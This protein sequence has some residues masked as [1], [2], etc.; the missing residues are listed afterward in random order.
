MDVGAGFGSGVGAVVVGTGVGATA[1]GAEVGVTVVGAGVGETVGGVGVPTASPEVGIG[2]AALPLVGAGALDA[3]VGTWPGLVPA[4]VADDGRTV[5][6]TSVMLIFGGWMGWLV[7]EVGLVALGTMDFGADFGGYGVFAS[8]AAAT[9]FWFDFGGA[10]TVPFF[11]ALPAEIDFAGSELGV[12]ADPWM[13]P[14]VGLAVGA[15]V[16]FAT[17]VSFWFALGGSTKASFLPAMPERDAA[18]AE[19]GQGV[20]AASATPTG[21]LAIRAGVLAMTLAG[22]ALDGHGVLMLAP[23]LVGFCAE[24]GA[25]WARRLGLS[26][27]I[28][29]TSAPNATEMSVR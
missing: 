8:E 11:P 19:N 18:L 27:S 9:S 16:G 14:L 21:N 15:A 7:T 26:A 25:S 1:V 29:T 23:P 2:W 13:S 24:V 28:G 17:E 10:V 20:V 5:T 12:V 6:G 4:L 22:L 3:G